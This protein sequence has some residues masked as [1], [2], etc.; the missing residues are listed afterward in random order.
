MH[1]LDRISEIYVSSYMKCLGI[2]NLTEIKT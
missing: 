2:S 1:K